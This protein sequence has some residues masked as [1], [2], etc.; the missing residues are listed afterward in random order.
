MRFPSSFLF[1]NDYR[2]RSCKKW[3]KYGSYV[4][5]PA[6][7]S[8]NPLFS[9]L[10][11]FFCLP[12][13]LPSPHSLGSFLLSS[14]LFFPPSLFPLQSLCFTWMT[15]K[16][17][18][19]GKFLNL[20]CPCPS[21]SLPH[22]HL[23]GERRSMVQPGLPPPLGCGG[24]YSFLG[25]WLLLVSL[26]SAEQKAVLPFSVSCRSLVAYAP[27]WE[28]E[29]WC[30]RAAAEFLSPVGPGRHLRGGQYSLSRAVEGCSYPQHWDR[31]LPA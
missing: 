10:L 11:F 19:L 2:F 28:R 4:L 23:H 24:H 8:G 30:C 9:F 25:L 3:C 21:G 6:S 27:W 16:I 7:P 5:H 14:C 29:L 22:Q 31:S 17:N 1:G 18:Y 26:L 12:V 13:F 15:R 20:I